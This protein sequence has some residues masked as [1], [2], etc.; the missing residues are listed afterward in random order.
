M[1]WRDP[2][3]VTVPA[4]LRAVVS[5]PPLVA[6]LLARRGL[7]TPDAARAFLDPVHYSPTPPH[8]MPG[9]Q[10]AVELIEAALRRGDRIG[11]WGDFDVDGQTATTIL[12]AALRALGG[13]VI[14]HI[15]VRATE[16]HGVHRPHLERMLAQGTRFL[17]TCD[18]GI[19]AHE[20]VAFARQQGLTVVITDHHELPLTLP[21]AHAIVNPHLLPTAHPLSTLPGVGV[22]YKL[23]EAL[24][25]RMGRAGEEIAYLDLVALGIVA[26]VA[27]VV[28]ETRYLLQ[29][30]LALLRRTPRLS[31]RALMQVARIRDPAQITEETIGFELGPRLNA[32]G[33]LGDANAIVPFLLTDHVAEA[34]L[35][36]AQLDALNR[37]RK[38]LC[39]QVERAAQAQL[40]DDP[41]LLEGAAL[42]LA[43]EAW[44][45]GIIGIVANRLATHYHRPAVLIATPP[46]EL[47]HGSARS[48][49]GCHITQ[50]IATQAPLLESFGGH[51]MA[52]GLS[53]H[54]EYIPAFRQGLSRAVAA[55]LAAAES[56][57]MLSLDAYLPLS[58]L[59][60]ALAD[61]LAQLGP[62]GPGNPLP[63]LATRN[64]RRRTIRP[65]GRDGRHVR[66]EVEDESGERRTVIWWRWDRASLPEGR[67]DLAY[68]LRINTYRGARELQLVW[69]DS[70]PSE[71]VVREA[72]R[73]AGPEV[74]DYR[75]EPHPQTL[76]RPLLEM[77]G[78]IV[79]AE[80]QARPQGS[81]LR[82]ELD[83]A[84]ILVVWT[85]PP[86][87]EEL[88]VVVRRVTP[89]RVYLF[90]VPPEM[91]V[92]LLF[93]RQLAGRV[94]YALRAL[95]G[96]VAIPRLAAA[97]AHREVT[98]RAGIRWLAARGDVHIVAEEDKRVVLVR[99]D[100]HP[101][102][103]LASATRRLQALLAE[104]TAYRR[105]YLRASTSDL[106]IRDAKG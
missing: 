89:Q 13:D 50:A 93:V 2:A 22:V 56:G 30:G 70:R 27:E 48:I 68:T 1:Q 37:R 66:L 69:E 25:R 24:Y 14:Y 33:R 65:L 19:D 18:T 84:P 53:L 61:A 100:G 42:V 41:T 7:L 55:Q 97:M 8:A 82:G 49:P 102:P 9:M 60:P 52:A 39:D 6:E 95:G 57:P 88:L 105:Y 91:D 38:W 83:T 63:I 98:V 43:H 75:R 20:A 15:P 92:P 96:E 54:P 67:F 87:P 81:F 101:T 73:P 103:E 46:G 40:A 106:L 72:V 31:L 29:R 3:P 99:G 28:G 64:L 71:V 44:P 104:T 16:S 26:D 86:G 45:G 79:W 35:M 59:T 77:E 34:R 12:V 62:F 10:T 32:L 85:V 74:V 78:V 23:V 47:G 11:V 4:A 76:L 36:A 51:A 94:K 80:G 90:A 21:D 17:L 58:A 5:G